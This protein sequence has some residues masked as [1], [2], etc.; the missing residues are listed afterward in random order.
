VAGSSESGSRSWAAS[1]H[2][3]APRPLSA[4]TLPCFAGG[5]AGVARGLLLGILGGFPRG[6]L[7]EF[8][9]GGRFLGQELGRASGGLGGLGGGEG[10][11]LTRPLGQFGGFALG[12]AGSASRGDSLP[13]RAPLGGLRTVGGRP[14]LGR[15]LQ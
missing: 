9:I 7:G 13:S 8:H 15:P 3:R 11:G 10:G 14:R 6:P 1:E 12:V 5:I 4:L 2:R